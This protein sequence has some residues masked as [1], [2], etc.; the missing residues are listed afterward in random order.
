ML[1]MLLPPQ[2]ALSDSA[3]QT[4]V[5]TVSAQIEAML[6]KFEKAFKERRL[7][8]FCNPDGRPFKVTIDH[9]LIEPPNGV[10]PHKFNSFG[11]FEKWLRSKERGAGEAGAELLPSREVRSRSLVG[12]GTVEYDNQGISH[13][14]LYL[15]R[16]RYLRK[17]QA[18]SI[19]EVVLYDGD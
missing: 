13:S 14:T 5:S 2:I 4:P 6:S 15:S 3:A 12:P 17:G 16:I 9:A 11:A 1:P 19:I 8:S 18:C 7:G 10:Q